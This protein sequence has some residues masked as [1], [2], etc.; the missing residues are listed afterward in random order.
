MNMDL[1]LVVTRRAKKREENQTEHIERSDPRANQSKQPE[2]GIGI[3]PG[4]CGLQDFILAEKTGESG[5]AC[6]RERG[7]KH[8]P[9]RNGNSVAQATHVRH[10]LIAAHG[11]NHAASR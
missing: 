1:M 7:N 3:R 2:P 6:D 11:V 8:G 10:F 5:Y 9:E 4:T